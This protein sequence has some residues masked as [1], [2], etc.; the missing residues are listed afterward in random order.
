MAGKA[1]HLQV[2]S[3]KVEIDEE[4]KWDPYFSRIKQYCRFLTQS[5]WD[6][7]DLAQETLIKALNSYPESS[8]CHSLLQKIAYNTWIDITRKK[9]RQQEEQLTD[10]LQDKTWNTQT[11]G[12]E[13]VEHLLE[14]L[15]P[16]QAVVLVLKEAFLYKIKEIAE[17]LNTTE[18]AV[19]S[20]LH[21][22]KQRLHSHG[23]DSLT[24]SK[25]V[26]FMNEEEERKIK[27][28]FLSAISS[29]D[30]S[31]LLI[32]IPLFPSLSSLATEPV[33]N[34]NKFTSFSSLYLAA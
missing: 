14:I 22:A 5:V 27:E 18:M 28:L 26:H 23:N 2:I 4:T 11:Q 1:I 29:D 21:R 25:K 15:T 12:N 9:A 7:D 16:K 10:Q 3:N 24:S 34:K 20:T 13:V 30:P 6:G 17:I 19:K 33:Q 8:V 32:A 31:V